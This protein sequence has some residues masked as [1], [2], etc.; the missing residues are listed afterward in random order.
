MNTD[1]EKK[2]NLT[3]VKLLEYMYDHVT[4]QVEHVSRKV[5]WDHLFENVWT[6]L[7][8]NFQKYE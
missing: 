8:G 3:L 6:P 5:V 1:N 4:K 7:N 2:I